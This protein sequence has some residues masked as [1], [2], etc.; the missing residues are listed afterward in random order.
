[1]TLPEDL[2]PGLVRVSVTKSLKPEGPGFESEPLA[3]VLQPVLNS[4]PQYRSTIDPRN[5]NAIKVLIVNPRPAPLTPP[6]AEILLNSIVSGDEPSL[7]YSSSR[8]LAFRIPELPLGPFSDR[9]A[10]VPAPL[11]AAFLVHA[12]ITLSDLAEWTPLRAEADYR[13][14][15]IADHEGGFYLLR[16]SSG[17]WGV[18]FCLADG[19]LPGAMAFQLPDLP[20]GNYRVR[21]RTN[22]VESPVYSSAGQPRPPRVIVP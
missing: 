7:A 17:P 18:Y 1:M 5:G 13:D 9:T 20:S 11:R 15:K 3:F 16:T 14:F 22:G 21:Y 6:R 10:P 2:Q 4:D 12:G 19:D 8:L